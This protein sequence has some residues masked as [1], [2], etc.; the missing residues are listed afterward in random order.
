[1]FDGDVVA[2]E[3]RVKKAINVPLYQHEYDALVSLA[4]N[5]GSLKKS[6]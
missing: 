6:A 3:A 4:F 5:M 2:I 1:M